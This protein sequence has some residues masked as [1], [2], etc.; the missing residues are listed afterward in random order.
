V[1][2]VKR[3]PRCG[4]QNAPSAEWC[5][6]CLS[7]F[8][9]TVIRAAAPAV[10]AEQELVDE[11]SALGGLGGEQ[12]AGPVEEP[13]VPSE[14][15]PLG[16]AEPSEMTVEAISAPETGA[17]AA[18][19]VAAEAPVPAAVDGAAEEAEADAP[20]VSDQPVPSESRHGGESPATPAVGQA[21]LIAPP[22][23]M[24]NVPVKF[25]RDGERVR[26]VCPTC[27]TANE[28]DLPAC[29]ICGTV[30]ARLFTP[31]EEKKR[32]TSRSAAPSIALSAVLPGLG[33]VTEG[34]TPVGVGRAVLYLWTVGIAVLLL[35]RPP[36][37]GHSMVRAVGV[38]FAAAA[39]AVW[40]ISLVETYRLS[41]GDSRP[42]VPSRTMTYVSAGL[43][44][45]LFLGL[46]AATLGRT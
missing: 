20:P 1:T 26:W 46:A 24:S 30:M 5:T 29:R 45:A 37:K 39:A 4:A 41:E 25:V 31:P 16:P 3:C 12:P 40:I 38:L 33:H 10:A 8:D 35:A 18:G 34:A 19:T 14:P 15:Q 42:V 44:L 22:P 2:D 43:T 21:G 23:P 32:K 7:R 36:S 11:I 6:L 17:G 28:I 9:G 13:A 27:E